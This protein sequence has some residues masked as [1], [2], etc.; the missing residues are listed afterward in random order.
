MA[1]GPGQEPITIGDGSP[2][3][4][5]WTLDDWA[6]DATHR[7]IEK[8]VHKQVMALQINDG[9]DVELNGRQLILDVDFKIGDV[10]YTLE[11]S[12]NATGR[13]LRIAM[14][15]DSPVFGSGGGYMMD[16]NPVKKMCRTVDASGADADAQIVAYSTRGG[17]Y[18][19][20]WRVPGP[21]VSN[22]FTIYL[23]L[24]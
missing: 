8:P 2:L 11:A 20:G 12:T 16:Y 1:I 13:D 22:T 24:I 23:S 7:E 15:D 17:I 4:I 5:K 9:A 21:K 19:A 18:P 10:I 14:S 6:L 3:K